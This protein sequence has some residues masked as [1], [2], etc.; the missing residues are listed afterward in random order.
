MHLDPR[1]CTL[2]LVHAPWS[3]YMHLDPCTCTLILVHARWS[4][5]MHLDPRT[6]TSILSLAPWSLYMHL[7]PQS[8]T[9]ILVHAPRSSLTPRSHNL[10]SSLSK[11]TV[12]SVAPMHNNVASLVAADGFRGPQFKKPPFSDYAWHHDTRQ[13]S[14]P[15]TLHFLIQPLQGDNSPRVIVDSST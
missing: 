9:L 6:C 8:C 4:S 5:Y 15:A 2:I 3:S 12:L 10:S 1:T 14:M 7:D 13:E 11:L